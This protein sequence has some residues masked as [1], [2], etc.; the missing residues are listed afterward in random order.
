MIII[1]P[2]LLL[3]GFSG[4]ANSEDAHSELDS[5]RVITGVMDEFSK[6]SIIVD[7]AR[8]SFCKDVLVF[9]LAG[10]LMRLNDME[11]AIEVKLFRTG[12]CVRKIA[13]LSFAQ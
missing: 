3:I 11:A 1:I 12:S 6:S 13:V 10:K 5:D 4:S 2:I 8:Y 9:N 7:G